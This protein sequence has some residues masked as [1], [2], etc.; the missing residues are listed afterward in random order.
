MVELFALS[1]IQVKSA[2]HL[3]SHARTRAHTHIHTR[4]RAHAH[5]LHVGPPVMMEHGG[6]DCCFVLVAQVASSPL[7]A[8]ADASFSD[9]LQ[10]SDCNSMSDGVSGK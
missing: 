4:T 1:C 2:S 6:C 10:P 7:S 3:V 8:G 9:H 5:A